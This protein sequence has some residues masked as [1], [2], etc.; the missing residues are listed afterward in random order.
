MFKRFF[1]FTLP[2]A[3]LFSACIVP[4]KFTLDIYINADGTYYYTFKGTV[5]DFDIL[6]DI[7]TFGEIEDESWYKNRIMSLAEASDQFYSKI[8]YLGNGYGDIEFTSASENE[9]LLISFLGNT[10]N[11]GYIET[12]IN[13]ITLILDN[14]FYDELNTEMNMYGFNPMG[15]VRIHASLPIEMSILPSDASQN[16]SSKTN[17]VSFSL[18]E[19]PEN[20]I[21]ISFRK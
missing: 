5:I 10:S 19:I 20:Q 9:L 8:E 2:L 12:N 15:K 16:I 3:I 4:E 6:Y 11:F 13:T 14:S 18:T 17:T 7:E 21:I 1:L